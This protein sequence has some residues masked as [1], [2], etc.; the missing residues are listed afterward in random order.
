MRERD[1]LL[2]W[3]GLFPTWTTNDRLLHV[4]AV[5]ELSR[6]SDESIWILCRLFFFFSPFICPYSM[7]QV[8]SFPEEA[9]RMNDRGNL[10]LH[11]ACSFQATPD[12]VETLLRAYPSAASQPNA[13][14]NLPLHQAAMWQAPVESVEVLL[15]RYPEGATVRNQ[16]GSLPLHM[17]ASNQ[18]TPEVV[19][20]LISAYPDALHLQNDDGMTP[21]DLALADESASDAVVA[22]LEGRPPP[23]ELTRRQQAEKFEERAKALERKLATLRDNGRPGQAKSDNDL[24][25]VLAAVRRLADRIPHSLYAAGMDP[26]ELEVAFSEAMDGRN[27][28]QADAELILME[29]I[30][31]RNR[32][33]GL[34]PPAGNP[35]SLSNPG[36]NAPRDRVEDLLASVV[37]LEHIKSQVR[38]LR[39]SA[40]I[41]DLR[42]SLIPSGGGGG[43]PFSRSSPLGLLPPGLAE[44][45]GRPDA[46]HMVFAGN[47][48][49]GKTAVARLLAKVFHELGLLRKPKFLEV[50]RMDLVARDKETTILKTREVLDE[51]RGGVLFVD[52]AFTLGMASKRNRADTGLHAL[53][54]I[55]RCI[56]EAASKGDDSFP[57]M[58]LVGFPLEINA[59]L[60]FQPDL[61]KR[62]PVTFEFP[63][64]TCDELARIFMDLAM[65]K[66]FDWN[67]DVTEEVISRL[68]STETTPTWRAERNGRVSEML[69]A[70]VRTQV[71]KRMRRAQM[72]EKDDEDEFDPQLIVRSDIENVMKTDFK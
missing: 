44:D 46:H 16:Y 1:N 65:A 25:V 64:Y 55:V 31:K 58:I 70:S 10:P 49:T 69:L 68:L 3:T 47:P 18:A 19:R 54:E 20:L 51:A 30:K 63:D 27:S 17:A 23:P 42:E 29:A 56:D 6:K 14:G 35:D 62:F 24:Q 36:N 11:A 67:D 26:N 13:T 15:A 7:M 32:I 5:A 22:M 33:K 37:G 34:V 59:F 66:G 2:D 53:N 45:T 28:N 50:E 4:L 39:R 52:E 43:R 8:P 57:L 40:E 48:G 60:A 21:L 41:S 72:E 12:V 71:R 38:G 61:R 9:S